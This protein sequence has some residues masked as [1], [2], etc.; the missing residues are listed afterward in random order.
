MYSRSAT[1]GDISRRCSSRAGI[2][3]EPREVSPVRFVC[4]VTS[5]LEQKKVDEGLEQEFRVFA[6]M[7]RAHVRFA[8][9]D[10][11]R[12]QGKRDDDA[13]TIAATV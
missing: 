6:P 11:P 3:R 7:G 10:P 4:A 1:R 12:Q 5:P 9:C 13:A 2:G 8:P